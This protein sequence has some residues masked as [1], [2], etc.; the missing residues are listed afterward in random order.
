MKKSEKSQYI[1]LLIKAYLIGELAKEDYEPKERLDVTE[2]FILTKYDND[3]NNIVEYIE[4]WVDEDNY[5]DTWSFINNLLSTFKSEIA[6]GKYNDKS[7]IKTSYEL[8]MNGLL[9]SIIND[10]KNNQKNMFD[11][12]TKKEEILNIYKNLANEL[13]I[14]STID[15][16]NYLTFLLWNGYFSPTKVHYYDEIKGSS[17]LAVFK[18]KGVCRNYASLHSEFFKLCGKK[19]YRVVCYSGYPTI[20]SEEIESI[21][22]R[23]IRKDKYMF[24]KAA[25]LLPCLP[26]LM[27]MYKKIGNH[28]IN[29]IEGENGLYYYDVTNLCVLNQMGYYGA[30]IVN[31]SGRYVIKPVSYFNVCSSEE[32][33]NLFL[34][35]II[36]NNHVQSIK[37]DDFLTSISNLKSIIRDNKALIDDTYDYARDKI[38]KL[39]EVVDERE[40]SLVLT[41]GK[42]CN[43]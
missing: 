33:R 12:D 16:S 27:P 43:R 22:N 9:C 3:L 26:I 14:N 11:V 18:G 19:S 10:K 40:K 4:K 37:F 21:V 20:E 23:N 34:K 35:M 6:S 13:G 8:I 39:N 5:L 24:L 28:V 29:I 36:E 41:K 30:S 25:L 17:S 1:K 42:R 15:L 38:I 2:G 7:K 31:G 32:I